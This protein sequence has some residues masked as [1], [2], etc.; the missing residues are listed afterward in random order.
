MP[1]VVIFQIARVTRIYQFAV[2]ALIDT[3][4]LGACTLELLQSQLPTFA[5]I[6]TKNCG[7]LP[8]I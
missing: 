1:S 8:T 2:I 6:S 5:E 7:N 4:Y 3:N